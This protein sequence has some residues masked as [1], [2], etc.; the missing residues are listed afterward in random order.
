MLISGVC[1]TGVAPVHRGAFIE[2]TPVDYA[3][4]AT[5]GLLGQ[6]AHSAAGRVFHLVAHAPALWE[7]VLSRI[8]GP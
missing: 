2:M 3:A 1:R 6:P 7:D 8:E 5:V 4:Q